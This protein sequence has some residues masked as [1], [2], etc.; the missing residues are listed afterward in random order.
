MGWAMLGLIALL[1]ALLL[2]RSGYPR[3]LWTVA[4]TALM[5]GAAGYAWQGSP[6]L[7]GHPVAER[8][9]RGTLDP[10]LIALR[11]AMYGQFTY[12]SQFYIA[13]D[14][15]TRI[16]ASDRAAQVM[17]GGVRKVPEDGALWS[18]LGLVLTERD[19]NQ[20]SPAARFALDKGVAL[21]PTHPGPQFVYGLALIREGKWQE[22]RPHWARAVELTP[23]NVSYRE[24]L[25]LRLLLLDRLLEAQAADAQGE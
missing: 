8:R 20:V 17:L 23:A 21:W 12:D 19:G 6:T 18:W 5:L 16:G 24:E 10:N 4:A 15:M 13:A 3:G 25:A 2:W 11:N 1:C 14:A 7:A 9:V 22:A